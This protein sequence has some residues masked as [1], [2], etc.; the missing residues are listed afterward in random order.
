MKAHEVPSIDLPADDLRVVLDDRMSAYGSLFRKYVIYFVALVSTALIVSGLVGLYFTYQESKAARLNLQ[1]EKAQA[2]A[3]RIATYVSE[4][5]HQLGW[6]RLPEAA[7]GGAE[8][9]RVEYLKLL[10]QE[11]AITDLTFIDASGREQLRVSRLGMS[12]SGSG[13]D[14]SR[15]PK[16]VQVHKGKTYFSPVY[17]RKQTEPYMTI[18][19][20][21]LTDSSGVTIAEVN[22]KFIWDVISRLKI[23]R[24]GLAYLVDSRG[25]LIAHPDISLVL[26]KTDLSSLAQVRAARA[27]VGSEERDSVLIAPGLQGGEALIGYAGVAPLGW[28]VF[29]EQPLAEA[30]GPLYS[31]L[32]RTGLLLLAGL[33]LAVAVSLFLARHMITP[34]RE[35][36]AGA[37]RIAAG[38]LDQ[39]IEIRTGDELEALA[40]EFNNMAKQLRESYSG[41]ERMVEERTRDLTA[42]LEQQTATS[43]V[44]KTISRSS[45]DLDRVLDE[46]IKC[47]VKLAHANAGCVYLKQPSGTYDLR[48]AYSDDDRLRV[49]LGA[50]AKAIHPDSATAAGRAIARLQP[51]QIDDASTIA[52]HRWPDAGFQTVLAVP[53]LRE[54]E[55][56]GVIVALKVIRQ[57]FTNKEIALITT[58]ADQAGIAIENV[59]LFNEIQQKSGE[60]ELAN[61]HKSEFL[62]NVSHE[63]RTP[64]NAIIGFSEVLLERMFGELNEKQAEYL[65]DIHSSGKHLL[66]LINDILNLAKIEAGRM[67]LELGRFDL[68]QA[69]HDALNLVRERAS[70]Q[71]ISLDLNVAPQ[72]GDW[73]ADELKVKQIMLNLLS[74]AVKFTP[75]G[76]RIRVQAVPIEG[77]VQIAVADSGIGIEEHHLNVI[78]E[79]FRQVGTDPLKKSEGTG[80]GL[81]LTKKFVELHGGTITVQSQVGKG[82]RFTFTLPERALETA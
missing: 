71:G 24:N 39:Q 48:G 68:R 3:S 9:R 70:R 37:A 78:F 67:D 5:E 49:F 62:A 40:V 27:D 14:F 13:T 31:S 81:A 34:I 8:R 23:G 79:E 4:I 56:I 20:P 55:P 30:F 60:L 6:V 76:G 45:F 53:I 51:V 44:L 16:F 1:R 10:R 57:A 61:R 52:E 19:V 41:L 36:Q 50:R 46:L 26:Q 64:L 38:T 18:A 21:G 2:A 69:L 59:R 11:P 54:G 12:V 7:E 77:G 58:F 33:I 28:H 22:L 80:L 25:Q 15:D 82:S 47:A 65:D 35:I 72:L 73:V 43:E 29:V 66:S 63:L 42:S 32:Q 17:F 75:E 74:N